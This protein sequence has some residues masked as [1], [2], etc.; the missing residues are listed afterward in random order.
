MR[1]P[2]TFSDLDR[3]SWLLGH[4]RNHLAKAGRRAEVARELLLLLQRAVEAEQDVLARLGSLTAECE[5]H[6]WP[7][8][9]PDDY[10]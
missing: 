7:E 10:E 2:V 1:A 5:G 6:A 4:A 8:P 3:G 9:S